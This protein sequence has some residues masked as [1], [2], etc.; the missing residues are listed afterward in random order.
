MRLPPNPQIK[1]AIGIIWNYGGNVGKDAAGTLAVE[2]D[3][4]WTSRCGHDLTT[5]ECRKTGKLDRKFKVFIS[6]GETCLR[7]EGEMVLDT[8]KHSS[9]IQS[10]TLVDGNIPLNY[11]LIRQQCN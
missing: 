9:Q 5:I 3:W 7:V 11:S 6:V 4:V 10:V 1:R 2:E 8:A